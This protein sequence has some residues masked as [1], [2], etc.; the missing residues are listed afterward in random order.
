MVCTALATGKTRITMNRMQA[1]TIFFMV[2][3][4][5]LNGWVFALKT[6]DIFGVYGVFGLNC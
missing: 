3:P 5:I 2:H 4:E 1:Q 6:L